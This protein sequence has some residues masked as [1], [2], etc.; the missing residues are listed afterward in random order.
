MNVNSGGAMNE[1]QVPDPATVYAVVE[2]LSRASKWR[3]R[4]VQVAGGVAV[5]AGLLGGLVGLPAAFATDAAAPQ[6]TG[7][8]AAAAPAASPSA[9]QEERARNA[10]FAAGYDYE[11]AERLAKLWNIKD[12]S[13][14]KAE[15]GRRLLA[16]QTLPF[17]ATPNPPVTES[18]ADPEDEARFGAYFDAGYD[19]DDAVALAKLWK[20]ASPVQAKLEAGK[21]LLAG[22]TLPIRP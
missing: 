15:A 12:I 11:D 10:Y 13:A 6:R 14:V 17:P 2:E 4:G 8:V 18:P 20:L 7:A 9:D 1:N 21:R 22:Q 5:G 16:G 3:R 19:Y